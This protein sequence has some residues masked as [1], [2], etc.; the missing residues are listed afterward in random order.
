MT[1]QRRPVA[2]VLA[3]ASTPRASPWI[4]RSGRSLSS[5]ACT[6]AGSRR[7]RVP[8]TS[9]TFTMLF[10]SVLALCDMAK[11]SYRYSSMLGPKPL[12]TTK[13]RKRVSDVFMQTRLSDLAHACDDFSLDGAL[14][15]DCQLVADLGVVHWASNN[16]SVLV[17][18]PHRLLPIF[19]G[20][21]RRVLNRAARDAA[22]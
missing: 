7:S 11:C 12:T 21:A 1:S 6:R 5:S 17:S 3:A 16:E 9:T 18:I 20:S 10:A 4:T 22:A 15:T 13:E 14:V 2:K 8:V 19:G